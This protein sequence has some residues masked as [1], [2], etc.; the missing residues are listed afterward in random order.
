MTEWFDSNKVIAVPVKLVDRAPE[1]AEEVALRSLEERIR[2][3][4]EPRTKRQLFADLALELPSGFPPFDLRDGPEGIILEV[5]RELTGEEV[6]HLNRAIVRLGITF[7]ITVEVVPEL[8]RK[9]ITFRYP[10]GQGDIDLIPSRCLS[11]KYSPRLRRLWEEDEEFWVEHRFA[12]LGTGVTDKLT[13]FPTG[14][15][16]RQSRCLVDASVFPPHNI[17][18]YLSLYRQVAI[19]APLAGQEEHVLRALGVTQ[20]ELRELVDLGRVKLLFPQSIDRYPL[21][22]LELVAEARPGSLLFSRRIAALTV[23]DTRL[24]FPL[25]YP[26]LELPERRALLHELWKLHSNTRDEWMATFLRTLIGELSRIWSYAEAML[27]TRGALATGALGLGPIIAETLY[28]QGG[29]DLRVELYASAYP[30]EWAGAVQANVIPVSLENYSLDVFYQLLANC[31]SGVPR[32]WN[33]RQYVPE[34]FVVER[35][36]AIGQDVPVVDFARSFGGG[37]VDRFRDL[38]NRISHESANP[39]GVAEVIEKFNSAVRAYERRSMRLREWDLKGLLLDVGGACVP[40]GGWIGGQLLKAIE[41][42]RAKYAALGAVLDRLTALM[43]RE[44]PE[45]ILVARMRRN[46]KDYL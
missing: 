10:E 45:T 2:M 44:R 23:C 3:S 27:H 33:A 40:F 5:T 36:L 14:W 7:P 13:F 18:N 20:N 37:D 22:L 46:L 34:N 35:I 41:R 1:G 16:E 31:Y 39:E 26:P 24:R 4:G 8:S 11:S 15:E 28:N 12:L 29:P 9:E 17:R 25:L 19:T 43:Y 38:V 30:V 6:E 32:E 42:S 21:R